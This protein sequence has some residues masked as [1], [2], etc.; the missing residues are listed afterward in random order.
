VGYAGFLIGPPL[1]GF[2]AEAIGLRGALGLIVA[3]SAVAIILAP[4][5]RSR[6]E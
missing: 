1:I 6:N 2:A 3:T 4:N 5:V